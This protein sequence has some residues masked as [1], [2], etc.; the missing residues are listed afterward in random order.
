M[1]DEQEE[2][3]QEEARAILERA[4]P[5][6]DE[7]ISSAVFGAFRAGG[8]SRMN[9]CRYMRTVLSPEDY[10]EWYRANFGDADDGRSVFTDRIQQEIKG[11][12]SA[13][14]LLNRKK[15]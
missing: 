2:K 15:P 4:K 1:S 14:D 5:F 9:L 6:T 3:F 8:K 11:Y 7:E 12:V 13:Q 10:V